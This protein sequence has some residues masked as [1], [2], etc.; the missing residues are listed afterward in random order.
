MITTA[1]RIYTSYDGSIVAEKDL[2]LV[3]DPGCDERSA[4]DFI[5]F[6]RRKNIPVKYAFLTHSHWDHVHNIGRLKKA[7][8]DLVII[9]HKNNPKAN[10]GIMRTRH[11]IIGETEY[12]L[13]PTPGHS[14]KEDD[15]CLYL[16]AE[17]V[18]FSGDTV[19]PQGETF[20]QCS[21]CTPVPY[22]EHGDQYV[23]SLKKISRLD[24]KYV[25]TGH[26]AILKKNSIDITLRTVNEIAG[27]SRRMVSETT[28]NN[29]RL[30]DKA[31]A[32][33]VFV[34]IS[35]MR[36]FAHAM[37]RLKDPYYDDLDSK[38]IIYFIKKYRLRRKKG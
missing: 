31:L 1:E 21:F 33:K 10:V 23:S 35:E 36:N 26:G 4:Q 29:K 3:V 11:F 8:K 14:E 27:L 13:I 19:Q 2:A 38:G 9:G 24:I 20:E 16:P 15:I 5:R 37:D 17:K 30:S 34:I 12:V 25:I 22:F 6:S 18:L 7:F 32:E 28:G